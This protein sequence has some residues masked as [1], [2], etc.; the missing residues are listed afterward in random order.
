MSQKIFLMHPL[1]NRYEV[2]EMLILQW[3][4][5]YTIGGE[6][7]NT[8]DQTSWWGVW[9]TRNMGMI[10]PDALKAVVEV[11][12][13][14]NPSETK[15]LFIAD[16]AWFATC[17][18]QLANSDM[19]VTSGQDVV[20]SPGICCFEGLALGLGV[21]QVMWRN[22]ARVL[23]NGTMDPNM[24]IIANANISDHMY[25]NTMIESIS[26]DKSGKPTITNNLKELVVNAKNSQA[27]VNRTTV[28]S[29]I[30]GN[31]KLNAA[32]QLGNE[33]VS[34]MNKISTKSGKELQNYLNQQNW[35]GLPHS[36]PSDIGYIAKNAMLL[37][38]IV[39]YGLVQIGIAADALKNNHSM[40]NAQDTAW[41]NG[42]N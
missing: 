15:S 23:W 40:L 9:V 4:L 22:D 14:T 12:G 13:F 5:T 41:M 1:D 7:A 16:Y 39:M 25:P 10:I 30:N 33:V 6:V 27:P 36:K 19:L 8:Q 3:Y 42:N 20:M 21:P 24:G 18:Y 31:S 34:K 26:Y 17:L 29:I 28:M 37:T 32:Y 35:F 2:A 11:G 38:N